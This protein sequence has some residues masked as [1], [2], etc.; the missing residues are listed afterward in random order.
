MFKYFLTFLLLSSCA[1]KYE[2]FEVIKKDEFKY[3]EN[4]PVIAPKLR[5]LRKEE[6]SFCKGQFLF[7][8]NAKKETEE[9]LKEEIKFMC[10]KSPYL[11]KTTI[12][13]TWWTVLLYSRACLNIETSC[14]AP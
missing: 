10:F 11:L 4:K 14:P 12:T 6:K 2:T 3:G 13:D 1:H 9:R 5:P 8:N 7:F